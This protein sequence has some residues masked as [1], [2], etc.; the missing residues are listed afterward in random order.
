MTTTD[1]RNFI[2]ACVQCGQS[3]VYGHVCPNANRTATQPILPITTDQRSEALRLASELTRNVGEIDADD[4]VV[5]VPRWTAEGAIAELRR[6][7]EE[8]E[9]LKAP[10]VR[11]VPVVWWLPSA[12]PNWYAP[13]W[14]VGSNPPD[15][16]TG[17]RAKEVGWIPLYAAPQPAAPTQVTEDAVSHW[18]TRALAAEGTLAKFK[19][20]GRMD[21]SFTSKINWKSGVPAEH[22]IL[23]ARVNP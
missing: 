10:A 7:A 5:L 1:Q 16:I 21:Y 9:R 20:V 3:W 14:H 23:Y 17:T 8:N 22:T 4:Q 18:R 2:N 13:V 12:A 15:H 19:Q 11:A 6:L